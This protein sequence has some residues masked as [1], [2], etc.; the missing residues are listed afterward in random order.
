MISN[1]GF[2]LYLA[3]PRVGTSQGGMVNEKFEAHIRYGYVA[4]RI[5]LRMSIKW[6]QKVG[7]PN[8]FLFHIRILKVICCRSK[9]KF[10]GLEM[11]LPYLLKLVVV[12]SGNDMTV[13]P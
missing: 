2:S 11:T 3:H 12:E 13:P 5:L 4:T 7:D 1:L 9:R 6:A 8:F 10:V